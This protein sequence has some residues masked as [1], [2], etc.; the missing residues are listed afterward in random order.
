MHTDAQSLIPKNRV[1]KISG[2][3]LRLDPR[4]HPFEIAHREEI[5]G[6]WVRTKALTPAL[7]DGEVTLFRGLAINPQGVLTGHFHMVRFSTLLYWRKNPEEAMGDHLFAHGVP[8]TG[9]GRLLAIRMRNDTANPGLVYFAA[10]SFDRDDIL[11]DGQLD[12]AGNMAREIGEETGLDLGEGT[13]D[14]DYYLYRGD[15]FMVLYRLVR[16]ARDAEALAADVRRHVAGQG[17]PEIEGP[18]VIDPAGPHPHGLGR[19]MPPFLDWFAA[20]VPAR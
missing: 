1:L 14:A 11:P 9:D 4:P 7:F 6:D 5:A 10:G 17:E 8:V 20:R 13:P 2:T 18:V 15:G 3:D 19:Q 16:F 12:V